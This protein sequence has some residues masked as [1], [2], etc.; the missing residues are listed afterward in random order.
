MDRITA[1]AETQKEFIVATVSSNGTLKLWDLR[2]G[3]A[4]FTLQE[5][6]E[7]ITAL[8]VCSENRLVAV[9]DKTT[10]KVWDLSMARVAHAAGEFLGTPVLTS[11]LSG[12]L[13]LVFYN[14]NHMVQVC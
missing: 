13:L 12:Q 11:A 5:V 1:I 7:N 10:I 4:I 2:L 6:G 14:G 9:S 8:V 3:K